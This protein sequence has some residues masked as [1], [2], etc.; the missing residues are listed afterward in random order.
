VRKEQL[1]EGAVADGTELGKGVK[2]KLGKAKE[3]AC[4][5]AMFSFTWCMYV[6]MRHARGTW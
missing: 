1:E 2:K 4:V 6:W 5:A 3:K